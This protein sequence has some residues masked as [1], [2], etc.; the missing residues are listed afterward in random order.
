M[1]YFGCENTRKFA[2]V[3][4]WEYEILGKIG[5]VSRWSLSLSKC[6][7]I[8]STIVTSVTIVTTKPRLRADN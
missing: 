1:V 2:Y 4:M 6:S 3:E 8:N 5:N 7:V